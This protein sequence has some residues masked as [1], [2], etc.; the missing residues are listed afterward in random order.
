MDDITTIQVST[1]TRKRLSRKK[2]H[3]KEALDKV[4]TRLLNYADQDMSSSKQLS[5]STIQNIESALDDIKN[6]RV[7]YLSEVEKELDNI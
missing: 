2:L 5:S 3:P 1:D 7:Y 6:G 4:I